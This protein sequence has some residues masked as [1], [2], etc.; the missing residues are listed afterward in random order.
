MNPPCYDRI[1][2]IDCPRRHAGCAATCP[3]W[4]EYVKERD[5]DYASRKK[6]L[7]ELQALGGVSEK[8]RSYSVREELR[9]RRYKP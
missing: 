8:R 5:R 3:E 2:H 9:L 4:A 6:T 1:N 7:D